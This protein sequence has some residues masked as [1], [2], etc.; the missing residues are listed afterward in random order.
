MHLTDLLTSRDQ[1][2]GL[3]KLLASAVERGRLAVL[4]DDAKVPDDIRPLAHELADLLDPAVEI[5]PPLPMTWSQF[6]ERLR[7]R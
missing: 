2:G 1:D 3:R 5:E 4:R 7:S 6:G